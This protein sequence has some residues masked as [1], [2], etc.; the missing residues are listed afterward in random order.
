MSNVRMCS[1]DI[2]LTTCSNLN[3]LV[4]V[5]LHLHSYLPN[6][7]VLH[8]IDRCSTMVHMNVMCP[9]YSYRVVERTTVDDDCFS[10]VS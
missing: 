7:I 1:H 9:D 8:R 5:V 2:D 4:A 10:D 3:E 6:E